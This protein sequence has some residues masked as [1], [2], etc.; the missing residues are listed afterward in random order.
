MPVFLAGDLKVGVTPNALAAS[1]G[2]LRTDELIGG[3][4]GTTGATGYTQWGTAVTPSYSWADGNTVSEQTTAGDLIEIRNA[5]EGHIHG[6]PGAAASSAENGSNSTLTWDLIISPN[7][8]TIAFSFEANPY[9]ETFLHASSGPGSSARANLDNDLTITDANGTV[10]FTWAPDGIINAVGGTVGGTELADSQSLNASINSLVPGALATK[11]SDDG[12]AFTPFSV[13][14]NQL[15][16]GAYKLSFV[17]NE[18]Q[19]VNKTVP[20]PA[21]LALLGLGLTGLAL[22]RRRKQA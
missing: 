15:A 13:V 19:V 14:S 8:G 21:T 11:Y 7:G 5:A 2:V 12:A 4:P 9:M 1:Q 22:T 3:T 17:S 18:S 10:V 20:E 16:A 6:G